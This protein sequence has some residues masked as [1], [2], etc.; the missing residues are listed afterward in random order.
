MNFSALTILAVAISP[1]VALARG[2]GGGQGKGCGMGMGQN[3][4]MEQRLNLAADQQKQVSLLRQNLAKELEPIWAKLDAKRAEI[5]VLWS[6]DK[7]ER[8][9]ILAKQSEMDS[10]RENVRVA[11]V[12]FRL[13]VHKLLTSEQR[14][15]FA[16][17]PGGCGQ[18]KNGQGNGCNGGCAC[19]GMDADL[20]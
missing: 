3:G 15:E 2:P 4:Q 5:Q 6:S 7:P 9:A 8:T 17:I 11:H 20:Y 16:V 10:L 14:K 18:M 13:A 1:V 12:D 19:M